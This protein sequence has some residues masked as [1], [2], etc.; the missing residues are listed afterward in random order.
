M[1]DVAHN[2]TDILKQRRHGAALAIV[3][4]GCRF[5]GGVST[6]ASFLALLR[7]GR[8]GIGDIPADRIDLKRYYD[9]TLRMPGKTSARHGGYLPDID[10]F[11]AEFFG[12]SPREA[13]RMDPQ[14]R[15]LLETSWEALED[16]GL[17]PTRL[18]GGKVGVFVGQWVSDFEQRLFQHPEELDFPMTLGSGRYALSGRISYLFGF[19]GPSMTIDTACSSSLVAVH[20]ASQSLRS[21]ESDVVIAGGVNVIL[22][23]HI[24]IAYS[25]GG[26]MASNGQCKFGD[27]RA[28]GYVR[29]EGA[30]IVALKRLEDALRDGDRIHAVIR[31][32]AVNNDGASSG[33]MGRPSVDGQRAAIEAALADAEVDP[34]EIAY[35]E[36]HGTGTPAGDRVEIGALGS[37]L[38]A[39]RSRNAPLLV[40]SVKTNIGHTE[41]A[42]GI[43][44]LIKATLAVRE[45]EIP[46]SLN[47]ETPSQL[48]DWD[49][50]AVEIARDARAWAEPPAARKAGVNG[51]GISGTNAHVI[52][53]GAP[54][55]ARATA[56]PWPAI[57]MLPLSA[58]SEGALRVLAGKVADLLA[59]P[60]APDLS[61]LLRFAQTRRAALEHRAAFLATS[62]DDLADAL[63]GYSKGGE[64]LAQGVVDPRRNIKVAL[65]FPGQGGQW[66]GMARTLLADEEEFRKSLECSDAVI[67]REA[68]WS[69]IEQLALNPGD[70]GYIGDR[71]DV[72][73]PTLG[74][75]A[76]AYAD[77][78]RAA[79]L[80]VDAVV[81]HSMG[82]AAAAHVAGALSLGDALRVLCRRSA[83]MRGQS[84]TGAM[85]VVDLPAK[86]VAAAL[87]GVEN[88]VS[89]AAINSRR[90]T[91]ISGDKGRVTEL[92]AGFNARGIFSRPVNVDVAS[93]SPQMDAASG[94]LRE[95]LAGTAARKAETPFASALFGRMVSGEELDAN[96]WARNLREPV[97]FATA[98]EALAE[99]NVG[100]FLELGPH[101]ILG[102]SIEQAEMDSDRRPVVAC[103]GRRE[104]DERAHLVGALATLWCAGA[105]IDFARGAT[106]P[107]RVI[108]FPLYPWMRRRHWADAADFARANDPRT[109][110]RG[111]GAEERE[112]MFETI[113]RELPPTLATGVTAGHWLLIG[114]DK[115]LTEALEHNSSSVES[116]LFADIEAR[117]SKLGADPV[118]NV[119]VI[120]PTGPASASLPLRVARA[121][122]P[123]AA[124]HLWF[125]TSGAQSPEQRGNLN[126]EHAALWGAARVLFDERPE[127]LGGLL[128]LPSQADAVDVATAAAWLQN[129]KGEDLAA[130]RDGRVHVPRLAPVTD[131][132]GKRLAWRADGAY[133]LTGGL[134]EVGLS[135]ASAMVE[136]GARRLILMS[137]SGLPARRTWADVD[138]ATP[139]GRRVAAVRAL[140]S[141]GASIQCPA[142]D[143]ADETAVVAFLADYAAEGW[144]PI[145]GVIHLAGV[146]DRRLISQ[147]SEAQ[148]EAAI[149]GKLRGAQVLDRLL[150]DLDCFILFS[151]MTTVLPQA[152]I[153]AYVAANAGLEALAL[154]RHARGLP[155]IAIA[156]GQWQAGMLADDAGRA[157]ISE[158]AKSGVGSFTTERGAN[159]LSWAAARP[160]PGIAVAPIDWQ[161]YGKA[162]AGRNEPLLSELKLSLA[163]TAPGSPADPDHPQ[164]AEVVFAIVRESVART[165]QFSINEID[166]AKEFGA[167]GLTSLLALE[168]RNRLERALGRRLPATLAWNFPTVAAL[169]AHLSG[170]DKPPLRSVKDEP[171]S[172]K[173]ATALAAKVA[174]VAALSDA[175]A[176]LAL[177]RRRKDV[178][179]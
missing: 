71:I 98:L 119:L 85:A 25:Q 91:V 90:S 149:A 152:G 155:A 68:G 62:V 57:P 103:C 147:T 63:R 139:L 44:G 89:I 51:F 47:F 78:M 36:A 176:L 11:D 154:D 127:L 96:Y 15:L 12:L 123:G 5:P 64:A 129:P 133:L 104:E 126:I 156:W 124:V 66:T 27:A 141:L 106:S 120:A 92:V 33:S 136:E 80:S 8:Q 117:L 170:A 134:G 48:V 114:A 60:D 128:D 16:A 178:L 113:W 2:S 26:M 4:I 50:A 30:G 166:P 73:Q 83:L 164:G 67:Q 112:W 177:R 131:T 171:P 138:P 58:R 54:A 142:V 41:S 87:T 150:P 72:V 28:D 79:G 14:Q 160:H 108:N 111:L 10:Q 95:G 39:G 70:P 13:E 82:E 31:G 19:T 86:D 21:G 158:Q 6:H 7:E 101:P 153:A 173:D 65:V 157:I 37:T 148:F 175:E 94:A 29:S 151:S 32:S 76:I 40:G 130:V 17:D 116:A 59:A 61:D 172:A 55:P 53:E 88:E 74:A 179:S 115:S 163:D 75:L 143:V 20:L 105:A 97:Q 24:H 18:R 109:A 161:V 81:G 1:R 122:G 49:A 93:H 3:G 140:E 174:A 69:L 38:G 45:G 52:I 56:T 102:P 135:V 43:A 118:T 121:I 167:M 42:A 144:P 23:P 137:R 34:L 110:R 9:P 125:V 168:L 165:L 100:A 145:R 146:L 99:R 46:A 159:I 169:S 107:A 35:V 77:W 22:G 132:H 84:G 162:R